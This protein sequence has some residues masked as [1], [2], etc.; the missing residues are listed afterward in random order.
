MGAP[1]AAAHL[2]ELI[3]FGCRKFIRCDGCG[4][5]AAE[6][7][8]GDILVPSAAVRDEGT[9]YH[10]LPPGREVAV[11]PKAFASAREV[12]QRRQV[13]HRVCKVWTTDA[14]YR[15]TRERVRRR[16]AEGCLVVEM[17]AAA[18]L[19]VAQ[20]RGAALGLLLYGGDDVSGE[21][22]VPRNWTQQIAIRERLFWLS[23]EACLQM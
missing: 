20:Y 13:D 7:A 21:S 17:E 3:A 9:S 12:L 5:L 11:T 2:E 15:E 14:F 1:I 4:V 6:I 18:Q 23:V 19:A 16:R 10:Y 22:H 8:C